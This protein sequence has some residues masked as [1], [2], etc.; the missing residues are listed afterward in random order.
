MCVRISKAD[1]E[2]FA[3]QFQKLAGL[4]ITFLKNFHEYQKHMNLNDAAATKNETEETTQ[5]QIVS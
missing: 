5:E 2:L 1:N 4:Q 3:I